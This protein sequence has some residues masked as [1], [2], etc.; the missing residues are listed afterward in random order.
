MNE[1][2][3]KGGRRR[4]R[5][6][7][8]WPLIFITAGVLFLLSN[9]GL[10]DINFWELWRLWPVL[11]ILVG[12]DILFGRRSALGSIFVTLLALAVLAGVVLLLVAAPDVLGPSRSGGVERIAEP[13]DGVERAS[14]D[15]SF[16]AGTLAVSRLADSSSLIEGDLEL[17]T[18]RKPTWEIARSG[19]QA[20]MT[21]QHEGDDAFANWGQGDEW[22]LRL[23][24]KAVWSLNIS[25]GAGR[26]TLDLTGLEIRDLDLDAGAGLTTVVFP[27]QGDLSARVSGGVGKL[28]IEIPREM[29][30]RIQVDRGPTILDMPPRFKKQGDV[31]V[32]E[33][34][35][36]SQN[37][38][39]LEIDLGIGAVTISQ[40]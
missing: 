2:E 13:L 38:I 3:E 25:V 30:A 37:R 14:L 23:S 29:A 16:A 10:L 35:D 24:P 36:T 27:R 22:D 20:D 26:A 5:P 19:S 1:K 17:A 6:S 12:L 21:L 39:D 8:V 31:Y 18:Q 40:P 11:L 34:W 7:L 4:W 33:G 15:V 9:L 28:E 32:T